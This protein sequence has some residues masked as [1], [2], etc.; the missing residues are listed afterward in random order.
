MVLLFF[1]IIFFFIHTITAVVLIPIFYYILK[2]P[3]PPL[4]VSSWE[5]VDCLGTHTTPAPLLELSYSFSKPVSHMWNLPTIHGTYPSFQISWIELPRHSWM[6]TLGLTFHLLV[7]MFLIFEHISVST[8]RYFY[9][10]LSQILHVSQYYYALT[11]CFGKYV[12][13]ILIQY[14]PFPPFFFPFFDRIRN[15]VLFD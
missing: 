5:L 14:S 10:L 6:N 11:N 12:Y 8:N 4:G 13:T 9:I 2:N 1:F 15:S 3:S 7:C